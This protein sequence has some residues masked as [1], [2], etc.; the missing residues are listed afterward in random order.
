MA[1]EEVTRPSLDA[2]VNK[3]VQD[4]VGT[5]LFYGQAAD[6]KLLV[7]LNFIGTQ[8][9]TATESTNEYIN[10]LLDYLAT[11][12]KNVIVYRSRSMVFVIHPYEVL[13]NEYKGLR[14]ARSHIFLA[15]DEP[16]PR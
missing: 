1:Q 7:A 2:K 16:V 15:K 10:L 4:I 5:V 13:H 8:H 12:P 11:Y 14:Q 6:K 9:A 3:C